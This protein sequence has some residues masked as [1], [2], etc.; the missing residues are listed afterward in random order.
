MQRPH[1]PMNVGAGQASAVLWP[2]VAG[3]S[4][5][6]SPFLAAF[7][8][9]SETGAKD[10]RPLLMNALRTGHEQFPDNRHAGADELEMRLNPFATTTIQRYWQN[11]PRSARISG[12][13]PRSQALTPQIAGAQ[14]RELWG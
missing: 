14:R 13:C 11:W 7:V 12:D 5:R 8:I 1:C 6:F 9:D 10:V 4:R 3:L 2:E